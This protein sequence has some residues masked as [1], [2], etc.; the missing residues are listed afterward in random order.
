MARP[1]LLELPPRDPRMEL[2]ARLEKAPA[3]HAEA[4]LAAYEV[5]QGLHDRGVFDLLRGALGS[6]AKIIEIAVEEA[7][8]PD[9]IRAL[10]NFLLLTKMFGAIDTERLTV[11]TEAVSESFFK[12]KDAPPPG[13]W[14]IVKKFWNRDFRRGV[15]A[16]QDLVEKFGKA[17]SDKQRS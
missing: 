3:E 13:I 6:S 1:I 10:R 8:S 2:R 5:L 9:S 15:G 12:P 17:L 11:L 16:A 4:L 14:G 7:K